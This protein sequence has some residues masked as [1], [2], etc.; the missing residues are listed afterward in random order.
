MAHLVLAYAFPGYTNTTYIPYQPMTIA[1]AHT[2]A[3]KQELAWHVVRAFESAADRIDQWYQSTKK[4][5]GF[6]RHFFCFCDIPHPGFFRQWMWKA[7]ERERKRKF[8]T[9]DLICGHMAWNWVGFVCQYISS[10]NIKLFMCGFIWW[11]LLIRSNGSKLCIVH[12]HHYYDFN[13]LIWLRRKCFRSRHKRMEREG[14]SAFKR[15]LVAECY[16]QLRTLVRFLLA[17]F[18]LA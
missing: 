11:F 7:T 14:A 2:R 4:S 15:R 8:S 17:T 9:R 1:R 6:E 16:C 3:G 5:R 18:F 13:L 10:Y 12:H